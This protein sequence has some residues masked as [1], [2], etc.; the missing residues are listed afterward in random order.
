MAL[1]REL[2]IGVTSFFRDPETLAEL[3]EGHLPALLE[4]TRDREV[5]F[6]VAGCSTGE[7]A[8]TLAILT[9]EAMRRHDIH[10]D[11]KIFATD[12]D[13][14]AVMTAGAGIYPESIAADLS[15]ELLA[16]YFYLKSDGYQVARNVREMVVFAQHNL[17]IG[18]AHV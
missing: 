9:K 17:E 12:I 13:R 2:L 14:D 8:Y 1:Y 16:H 7:E 10:R 4:R 15:P 5:R 6:W 11:V 18:R 3:A